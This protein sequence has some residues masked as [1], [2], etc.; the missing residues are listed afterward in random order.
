TMRM[1]RFAILAVLLL[2]STASVR[3]GDPAS[4]SPSPEGRWLVAHRYFTPSDVN[5]SIGKLLTD[6][7]HEV[8]I[9]NGKMSA[10]DAG[11][12]GV[13]VRIDFNP[14]TTQKTVN[15]TST[16]EPNR[17]THSRVRVTV[18]IL[19]ENAAQLRSTT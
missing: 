14:K 1:I 5:A 15:R 7:G 2:G 9:K 4:N 8:E 18:A 13:Y 10:V 3:A 6:L 19:A 17:I 16:C 12:E 11:K